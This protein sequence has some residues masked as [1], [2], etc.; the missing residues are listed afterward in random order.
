MNKEKLAIWGL[1]YLLLCLLNTKSKLHAPHNAVL[2][3][4]P[5]QGLVSFPKLSGEAERDHGKGT[6]KIKVKGHGDS[7]ARTRWQ[8]GA[9]KIEG[10][11]R[12]KRKTSKSR[13][14]INDDD[15]ICLDDFFSIAY[16]LGSQYLE[17]KNVR[18]DGIW[19][20][21]LKSCYLSILL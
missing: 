11:L 12:V 16:S 9:I 4:N 5:P 6:V 7:S 10:F 1:L 21:N 20:A 13:T 8:G 14:I 18:A 2:G 15:L 17:Q 19:L 3:K